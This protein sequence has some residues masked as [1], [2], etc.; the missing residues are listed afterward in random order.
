M[1]A[2]VTVPGLSAEERAALFA[3]VSST[4]SGD[5]PFVEAAS[6]SN[7]T[8]VSFLARR[9]SSTFTTRRSPGRCRWSPR[10]T[11]R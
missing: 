1:T 2:R 5:E 4:G 6:A 7:G 8:V 11:G 10:G 3:E 9:G